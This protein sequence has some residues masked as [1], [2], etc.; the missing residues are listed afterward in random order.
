MNATRPEHTSPDRNR[1]DESMDMTDFLVRLLDTPSPTGMTEQAV[2]VTEQEL[3]GMNVQTQRTK[4]GALT[5]EIRGTGEGHVTFS[6]HVDTL[7]AMVKGIK[8]NGR[9]LL[10]MIGGYDWATI[11]GEDVNVHTQS[12]RVVTGTVVNIRQSTHVHGPALRELKREQAVMEVRLDEPVTCADDTRKLGINVGDFVS[13]DARPRV[14]PSG[15]IKSRHLDNKAAV[16]IFI[17][18][19]RDLLSNPAPRTAHF[20]IT[21]YEEVGHGAATGIPANTDELIAV[22]MAAVGEGQT[23]N[24]HCVTLC[25]ADS[26]GPYDHHL[27]NRLRQTAA[28]AGIDLRVDIYPYYGSDGSAAWRAGGNYP[29]ALIGPGVDASH[30]YERMHKDALDATRNLILAYLRR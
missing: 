3:A 6:A 22:D 30:A 10:F 12:G 1:T 16:A 29:V 13:L 24:E 2:Q 4:K 7:G 20:H 28:Q 15:Y 26:S 21:T 5:W 27:G 8:G 25:V 14:T 11:E 18:A 17:D 19:T 23:S 9:L